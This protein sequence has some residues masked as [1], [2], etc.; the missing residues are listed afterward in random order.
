[1]IQKLLAALLIVVVAL[2]QTSC[3]KDD[4]APGEK[5]E[6]Y[7]LQSFETID[8]TCQID[9]SKFVL[10]EDPLIRYADL[11]SYNSSEHVFSLSSQGQEAIEDF[12]LSIHKRAF[13]IA[14]DGEPIYTA[15]F[16]AS[17]SSMSCQWVVA[18]PFSIDYNGGLK[19]LLGYPGHMDGIEI[20]DKRNDPH[21]LTVF[22]RD[23][24]LRS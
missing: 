17:F 10:E 22:K 13:A 2:I 8:N 5:V 3:N 18:D 11:L 21:L 6:L 15:Y 14:V 19:I 16:W 1:M 9:E 20:P 23:G 24:K 7:L 4:V 12:D